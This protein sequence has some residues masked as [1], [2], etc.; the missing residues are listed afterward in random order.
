[1]AHVAD[2]GFALLGA[3]LQFL[4]IADSANFRL[5]QCINP[6]ILLS[7]GRIVARIHIPT[8]LVFFLI[9]IV[10]NSRQTRRRLVG[11]REVC[12]VG[13]GRDS[14]DVLGEGGS[15]VVVGIVLGDV[16]VVFAD[17]AAEVLVAVAASAAGQRPVV[18]HHRELSK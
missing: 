18:G 7:F 16:V 9:T 8:P 1:L 10:V 4:G 13:G 2:T 17:G 12:K 11:I 3:Q 5:T 14:F 15:S 6:R